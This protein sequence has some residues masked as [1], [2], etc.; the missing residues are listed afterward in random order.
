MWS[1]FIFFLW[2]PQ[3][4]W[5]ASHEGPNHCGSRGCWQLHAKTTPHGMLWQEQGQY[6][7]RVDE[8]SAARCKNR[9]DATDINKLHH[10]GFVDL[11]KFGRLAAPEINDICTWC[12]QLLSQNPENSI[13]LPNYL[14]VYIYV[15][16]C[17]L[18][19]GVMFFWGWCECEA[20]CSC[21]VQSWRVTVSWMDYEESKG[22]GLK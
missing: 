4:V 5:G 20:W 1:F 13:L 16:V 22:D 11:S 14:Y 2:Y 17:L 6:L 18:V 21:A 9:F 15:C 19:V 12:H 8:K 7:F 3:A 10:L